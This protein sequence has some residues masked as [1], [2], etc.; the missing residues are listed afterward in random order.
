MVIS[1]GNFGRIYSGFN[2]RGRVFT[3]TTLNP[4]ENY[5]CFPL[6]DLI[7]KINPEDIDYYPI[8][9][10]DKGKCS[11]VQIAR[12]VQ[13]AGGYMAMI[14]ND[15]EGDVKNYPVIDDGT[16]GDIVIP[17]IL[18]SK[19][20]GNI[21]K[22]F[23]QEN[24]SENIQIEIEFRTEKSDFVK[25]DYFTLINDEQGYKIL[26]EFST[27]YFFLKDIVS[28]TPHYLSYPLEGLTKAEKE[29]NCVS[30]GKYCL[31]G[32]VPRNKNAPGR[33]LLMDSI[34][35]Q[36]FHK[37][38]TSNETNYH[39]EYYFS[40]TN[41]YESHCLYIRYKKFCGKSVLENLGISEKEVDDCIYQSFGKEDTVM[42]P[43]DYANENS[44]LHENY[45]KATDERIKIF[46][47]FMVNGK[48]LKG[49]LSAENL[50]LSICTSFNQM[51]TC[52][53]SYFFNNVTNKG[54]KWY[55]ILFIIM[56][57]VVVNVAVIYLCRKYIIKRIN[58][59]VV[60]GELDI[61][62]R[63]NSVVSSYFALK[64]RGV[65]TKGTLNSNSETA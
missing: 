16:G 5:A 32:G 39:P 8:I 45:K 24:P 40:L 60:G 34:F 7:I 9:L 12:M 54:L 11:Y 33:S 55:H 29:N 37:V 4:A 31:T 14:I 17:T 56:I 30:G 1:Y 25:V 46:P 59:R 42:K 28:F 6:K 38:V 10:V 22:K 51:P 35:H 49:R 43:E 53:Q 19:A 48:K 3:P 20:D 18:I 13:Q 63:I 50:F 44:I 62:G 41:Y 57:V 15:K 61:D 58:E 27:F 52:C 2:T 65:T 23:I 47:T 26:N 64:E 21:I 36:C